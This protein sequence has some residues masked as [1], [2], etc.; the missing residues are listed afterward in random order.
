MA[1]E[2]KPGIC[3]IG[4]DPGGLFLAFSAAA[5]GVPVV[6]TEK[7]PM[8][9]EWFKEA[10]TVPAQALI[11]AAERA[12]AIRNCTSFGLKTGRFGVNFAAV[13]SH[14]Q[15]VLNAVA[16]NSTRARVAGLGIGLIPGQARFTDAATVAIDGFNI[17][18]ERFVIATGSAPFIPDI[19][20]LLDTPH[21]T[22]ENLCDL[23]ECP[24]HLIVVGAGVVGLELAQAFRRLGAE[25]TVLE[26]GAM[27]LAG[28]DRE[29]AAIVL[30]AI[31]REGVTLRTEVEITKV[32]RV[33]SK[34]QV[35][36]A[37]NGGTQTIEA[38]HLL[39]AAG[40]RP[41]LYDL[42]LDTADV[43]YAEDR[44]IV[45]Q[46]LRTTNKRIYAMGDVAGGPKYP[47]AAI[48]HAR[49]VLRNALFHMPT[50]LN[51]QIIPRVIHTDPELA[52]VGLNEEESRAQH[53]VI[54]VL[55]WSYRE[56]D[57]AQSERSTNGNV[58]VI[59]TRGGKI[60][61]VTIV[62]PQAGENI[63]T[64]T[65]A[66]SQKLKIGAMAGL[67]APY[68]SYAEMGKYAALTYYTPRLTSART[69]RIIGWLRRLG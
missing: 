40:R 45:D 39:I 61:G 66:I 6:L 19:P 63:A 22:T 29:C 53:G 35:D 60:L 48:Y 49:V 67:V 41:H 33:N 58:K 17:K 32:R 46:R 3:V 1:Q 52:H 20:G 34:V 51:P 4:A 59:T 57:R 15:D 24:R 14:V 9:R 31:L 69:R 50:K 36:I 37:A 44:I 54:R 11:A 43:R 21:F 23:D 26:A 7:G 13:N 55:R 12:H 28:N 64:W 18:A 5:M 30:E 10:G 68:A 42:N 27:P 56:S 47:H 8:G 2:F 25:V 62:G 65:L 16:P 38:T